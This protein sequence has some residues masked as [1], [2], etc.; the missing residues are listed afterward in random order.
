M[1]IEV[2]Y[3]LAFFGDVSLS[4]ALVIALTCCVWN[5]LAEFYV[6][7]ASS[8]WGKA[9]RLLVWVL[10]VMLT[11]LLALG[12]SSPHGLDLVAL[13]KDAHR[14]VLLLRLLAF[15]CVS[16]VAGRAVAFLVDYLLQKHRL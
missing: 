3:P 7:V 9:K 14:V 16:L 8:A 6:G 5:Q 4:F 1:K 15:V 2:I 13:A 10:P 11:Y 12:I